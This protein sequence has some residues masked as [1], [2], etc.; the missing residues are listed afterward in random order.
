MND[1]IEGLETGADDYL[2]KPFNKQE[3][4]L[5]INNLFESRK[6]IRTKVI[7]ELLI[8]S[9]ELGLNPTDD[10]FLKKAIAL[11]EK[12]MEDVDFDLSDFTK[13]IGLSRTHLY[14][15]LTALTNQSATEFIRTIRL[16][17]AAQLIAEEG[18]NVNEVYWK[19]GFN[20]RT[21]FTKSF[22][23]LFQISPSKYKRKT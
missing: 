11:V 6:K 21:H 8:D 14:N 19:V 16:K 17:K 2:T 9:K 7:R 12:H 4:L 23:K 20:D 3:L 13:E 18:L 5:R 15:K 10:A 22:T 1:K